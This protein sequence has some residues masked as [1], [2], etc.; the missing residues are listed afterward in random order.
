MYTVSKHIIT[1][2]FENVNILNLNISIQYIITTIK[3]FF[4]NV[5]TKHISQFLY[6][7]PF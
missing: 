2:I 4:F 5:R 6:D 3:I 7:K 1:T